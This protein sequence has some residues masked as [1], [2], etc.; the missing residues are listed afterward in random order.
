MF[1]C[2][3][4]GVFLPLGLFQIFLEGGGGVF[5]ARGGAAFSDPPFANAL[6]RLKGGGSKVFSGVL[7]FAGLGV[8]EGNPLGGC[9]GPPPVASGADLGTGIFASLRFVARR[10]GEG[11]EAASQREA[12]LKKYLFDWAFGGIFFLWWINDGSFYFRGDGAFL[13]AFM[14]GGEFYL[15]PRPFAERTI[16][17][18]ETSTPTQVPMA[19]F[20]PPFW[21][22]GR[23]VGGFNFLALKKSVLTLPGGPILRASFRPPPPLR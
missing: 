16:L 22:L 3:L 9:Q 11:S 15:P 13:V 7:P 17:L 1:F 19:A 10:K 6:L 12:L 20:A 8:S 4:L 14:W 21:H 5:G 2:S 18:H 23:G